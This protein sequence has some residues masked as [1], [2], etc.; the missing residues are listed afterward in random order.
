MEMINTNEPSFN[1]KNWGKILV[2]EDN[3]TILKLLTKVLEREG[4]Q[5]TSVDDGLSARKKLSEDNYDIVLSDILIPGIDGIE[6][7]KEIRDNYSDVPVILITGN[8]SLDHAKEAIRWGAFD[9]ITKPF[10]DMNSILHSIKRAVIKG[11]LQKEKEDLIRELDRKNLHL[12]NVVREIDRKNARLDL[13]VYDLEQAMELGS[14]M[15]SETRIKVIL[16]KIHE[17]LFR[18]FDLSTW[19]VLLYNKNETST[20]EIYKARKTGDNID[21]NLAQLAIKDFQLQTGLTVEDDKYQI[22]VTEK[23]LSDVNYSQKNYHS[24]ILN[25]GDNNLGLLF[26]FADF[27]ESFKKSKQH[28]LS[29]IANQLSAAI[30]NTNLFNRLEAQNA[31]LQKLSDFKDEVLHIVAHDLRAPIAAVSMTANLLKDYVHKMSEDEKKES[32]ETIVD[33]SRHISK[34]VNEILDISVIEKGKLILNKTEV[35]F[36]QLL[37]RHYKDFIPVARSKNIEIGCVLPSELPRVS[38]DKGKIGEVLDNLISNAVKYTPREGIVNIVAK[39]G[40]EFIEI[41]V[42]DNGPGIKQNELQKLFK[43]FSTTSSRPTGG[44]SSFGLGLAISK[45]IIELHQGTIWAESE[46]G[47]GSSFCFRLPVKTG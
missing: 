5:V 30:Q 31:K 39:N 7:L 12:K 26:V 43:K 20:I 1:N 11:R 9:Y 35:N 42:N 22:N 16:D 13:L 47:K 33:K 18:I 27:K 19:G 29:L 6:L 25:V 10:H 32:M 17:H 14:I 46:Y 44:E 41:R 8:R 38:I 40:G 37:E 28:T 15:T 24:S 3:D 21:E 34:M 2:A 23:V 45:Q 36:K 4:Y